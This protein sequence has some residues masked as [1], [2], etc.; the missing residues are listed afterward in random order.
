MER[1]LSPVRIPSRREIQERPKLRAVRPKVMQ[2]TLRILGGEFEKTKQDLLSGHLFSR[3][4]V[5]SMRGATEVCRL[6]SFTDE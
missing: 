1:D 6:V 4:E 3:E 2:S 5:S